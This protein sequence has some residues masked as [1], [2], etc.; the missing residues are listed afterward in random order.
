M[1][2]LLAMFIML[3]IFLNSYF[4]PLMIFSAIPFGIVGALLGHLVFGHQLTL[5]S[6]AGMIAVSG[7]VVNNNM[8]II[9]FINDRVKAGENLVDTILLAGMDRFRPIMLTT[10]TTFAGVFPTILS[11]SWEAQFLI[12]LAISIGCGVVFAA[13]LTLFLVPALYLISDDIKQWLAK[14]FSS[15]PAEK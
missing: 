4:Q 3:A 14:N 5:W 8:V 13:V 7:I 1:L 2:S 9:F 6:L 10:I 12:P 11:N 15:L